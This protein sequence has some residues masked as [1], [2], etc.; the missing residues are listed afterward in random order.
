M[1]EQTPARPDPRRPARGAAPGLRC[2]FCGEVVPTVRRVAVDAG[3]ERLQ[4]PH[5][6]LY[7]CP[8]C[9]ERKERARLGLG[10]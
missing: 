6:E 9:S 7:A 4:T 2:D 3:Y 10:S 1:A 8:P 5:K